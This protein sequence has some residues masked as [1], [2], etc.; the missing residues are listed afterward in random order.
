MVELRSGARPLHQRLVLQASPELAQARPAKIYD[1]GWTGFH[2]IPL[3]RTFLDCSVQ[4]DWTQGH[5]IAVPFDVY[6][7]V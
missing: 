4:N 2:L 6:P 1:Y 3:C 5:Y 7:S